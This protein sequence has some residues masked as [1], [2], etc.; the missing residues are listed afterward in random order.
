MLPASLLLALAFYKC[1]QVIGHGDQKMGEGETIQQYAAR[2][3]ATEHHIDTFDTASFFKLH[4]L[5]RDGFLDT[6][7][8]E[9]IYGV[10]H[11]YSQQKSKD[12]EEHAQKAQTIV[13]A[14]LSKM[15]S[16]K[17][18][19]VSLEEFE[20]QG[21]DALPNFSHLGAD[22]HHYD[23]ES[24]FFLH[25]EEMYHSTPET[26]TD[27][28]YNHPEDLEHF[29]KHE[30]IEEEE[31]RR[32][33]KFTGLS[34]D[35]MTPNKA[36]SESNARSPENAEPE[37]PIGAPNTPDSNQ[38]TPALAQDIPVGDQQT[39]QQAMSA[40]K[41]KYTREVPPEEMEPAEKYAG[42]LKD[43]ESLP[44][45]GKGKEGYKRPKT[46]ADRMRRNLPYKY[47]FR[48]NWGDF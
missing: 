20:K 31:N 23:M 3:M 19:K 12:G 9:A 7:E 8:I 21:L 47:K 45:W 32:E 35:E 37:N 26:Q 29:A 40:A 48:R 22:G 15:D 18:G 16:N 1:R 14:I 25:H 36:S 27:D 5:N 2:H 28:A 38:T 30:A 11:A 39:L 43:R 34:E 41:P 33:R 17:D 10:H 24:E 44:E 6:E 13:N 42:E 46:P 4:D